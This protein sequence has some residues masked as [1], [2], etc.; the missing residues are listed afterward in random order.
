MNLDPVSIRFK[1]WTTV[2]PWLSIGFKIWTTVKPWRRLKEAR[3]RRRAKKGKELLPITEEDDQVFPTNTMR[4]SGVALVGLS[5]ILGSV[6]AGGLGL[7]G[8]GECTPEQVEAGC[9]GATAIAA[10]LV[11]SVGGVLYWIGFN[12]AKKRGE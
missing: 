8:V 6:I 12:R 4:K 9:V 2:N 11:S 3:N 7:V 1:I 5:P 10:G